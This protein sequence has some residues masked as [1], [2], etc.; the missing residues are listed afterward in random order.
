MICSRV[1]EN[2]KLNTISGNKSMNLRLFLNTTNSRV[3]P[4]IDLERVSTIL[5]SNRINSVIEDYSTDSRVN[6]IDGDPTACQY[7]SK[8]I[9]LENSADSIKIML[10]AH[11]SSNNDIRA[12][13]AVSD[14]P[15]FEPIF[16]PFPGH[17]NLDSRGQVI[18][19]EDSNGESDTIV[20]KTIFDGFDGQ[21]LDFKEYT[22]TANSL[23]P[24]RSYRVKI[25]MT[26]NSQV[27][28]PRMKDLRV[29]TMV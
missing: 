18:F 11:I 28:V 10:N 12:F 17:E 9:S 21:L 7:V 29:I 5:T 23:P 8:E 25:V 24:F 13:Y 4:V 6:E 14:T 22:F 26:S 20:P 27:H 16:Q 19:E 3:S 1:N 15:G 2:S